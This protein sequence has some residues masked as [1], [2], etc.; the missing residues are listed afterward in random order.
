MH[1]KI[2][3]S[4]FMA[5]DDVLG[6][7]VAVVGRGFGASEIIDQAHRQMKPPALAQRGRPKARV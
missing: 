6:P 4:T 7:A 2:R 5:W 1:D 3:D